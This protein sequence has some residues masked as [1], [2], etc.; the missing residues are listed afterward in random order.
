V[1]GAATYS[2][3]KGSLCVVEGA[4]LPFVVQRIYYIHSVPIGAVRGEHG[5]R[6]LEQIIMCLS[7]AVE[8]MICDGVQQ[9][10]I[11]LSDPSML[12][13]VPPGCWRSVKFKEA[14]SVLCVL[15]SMPFDR[16][17][18]IYDYEEFIRWK[19]SSFAEENAQ[20]HD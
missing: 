4:D 1:L 14:G 12:L 9:Q 13:H 10:F 20:P 11:T 5:H 2:D 8:V 6:E 16:S 15:A 3:D 19:R 18:Y 7:G 17:D